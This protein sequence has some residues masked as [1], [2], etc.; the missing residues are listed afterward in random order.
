MTKKMQ[1][2]LLIYIDN[3]YCGGEHG[4]CGAPQA[5]DGSAAPSPAHW[6]GYAAAQSHAHPTHYASPASSGRA[7]AF[8][9]V[10]CTSRCV[11]GSMNWYRTFSEK[12]SN[13]RNEYFFKKVF[14]IVLHALFSP[15]YVG[16]SF[17]NQ[18]IL[19]EP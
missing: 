14:M 18:R 6:R 9:N 2:P 3:Y 13:C 7:F 17:L 10:C 12:S 1:L 11:S 5:E 4:S 16:P 15:P 19:V 8:G